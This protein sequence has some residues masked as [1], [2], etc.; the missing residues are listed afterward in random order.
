MTLDNERS[1]LLAGG[2]VF[3]GSGQPL[4][5]GDVLIVG[6]RIEAVVAASDHWAAP[7]DAL[8]IDVGGRTV[9][10]GLVDGHAHISFTNVAD[11][12]D[13]ARMPVEENL[14]AAICNAALLLDHGF[15]SLVSAAASKPRLD[16]AVRNAIEAGQ[17]VGPRM[18]AASQE[19][20]PTGNLGDLDQAH[21]PIPESARFAYIC[22]GPDAFRLA[23]RRFAREGV[24][25]LKVNVSGD[26]DWGHMG[27]DASTTLVD[28]DELAALVKVAHGRGLR[29]AA[30]AT[31][32]GSVKMCVRHGVDIIYH[33]ALADSEAL[34]MVESVKDSVFVAPAVGF[35]YAYLHEGE[36]YG[37]HLRPKARRGLEEEIEITARNMQELHRRGVRIVPGGDYGLVC[38]PM[39]RNARDLELFVTLFGFSPA[40]SLVAATN[41][42]GAMMGRGDEL[43]QLR[44]GWLA[45][46]IVV[47]GD[48]LDDIAVL[49]DRDRINLVMKDGQICRNDLTASGTPR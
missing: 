14:I 3:D 20:T 25:I 42:G 15:T 21:F 28:D 46:L 13:L 40:D 16:V 11:L 44:A 31:S 38:T 33:A 43:G 48:P 6:N 10:P 45:D 22:D 18:L 41:H 34:D 23:A 30:H 8:R 36:K 26:R 47:D 39:G 19:I 9:M 2:M 12:M 1:I 17:I 32:A 24:D 4:F 27:A 7:P 35:P 5:A 49:Q 37:L 29:V